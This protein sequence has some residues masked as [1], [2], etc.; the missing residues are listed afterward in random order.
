MFELTN[1]DDPHSAE[2]LTAVEFERT[3][4]DRRAAHAPLVKVKGRLER[5]DPRPRPWTDVKGITLHQTACN[6][7]ERIERYDTIGAHF[8]VLRSGRWLRMADETRIVYHGNG[9]NNQC[10]GVEVDGLYPGLLDD[11]K[12]VHDEALQSTWD[13]PTTPTREQ[14]QRTTPQAMLTLRRLCRWIVNHVRMNGGAVRTLCAHRQSSL[15]RQNDPG[16]EIWQQAALPL[17]FELGLNDGGVGFRLG[18]YAIP[19]AWDPRCRGVT[20]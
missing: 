4:Y 7:G 8:A 6:M 16:Q 10:V 18:G 17:L 1:V 11:P 20:Y 13:D 9:W 14:P 19:E 2:V 12:T 15:D 3:G 5:Y